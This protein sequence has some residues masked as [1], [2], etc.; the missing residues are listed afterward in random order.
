MRLT[1][2]FVAR[3]VFTC[4]LVVTVQRLEGQVPDNIVP[5]MS[6]AKISRSIFQAERDNAAR[7]R[8]YSPIVEMY[9]Q[10]LWPDSPAQMPLDDMYSLQKV[11][12]SNFLAQDKGRWAELV[13]GSKGWSLLQDNGQRVKLDPLGFASLAFLDL[14]NFDSDT[15]RL[16]YIAPAKLGTVD[17][18]MLSVLPM[19]VKGT[20]RFRGTIWVE[21][22]GFRIIR[23]NGTFQA[24][25]N[26]FAQ[27]ISHFHS[28]CW[29]VEIA[30]GL[31]VPTYVFV[32]D[33]VP[34]KAKGSNGLAHLHIKA[35]IS[36]W[37]YGQGDS[38][39]YAR[40]GMLKDE[41]D[42]PGELV[43][44]EADRLI[45]PIGNV[46][47]SLN[48]IL[49]EVSRGTGFESSTSSCRLLLTAPLELF[50][51]RDTIVLSRG[52]LEM[53]P[54]A[55]TLK[56]LLLYELAHVNVDASVKMPFEYTQSLF[57]TFPSA[58][59]AGLGIPQN[60]ESETKAAALLRGILE[61]NQYAPYLEKASMFLAQLRLIAP[62]IP[63]LTK[64]RFGPDLLEAD[65]PVLDLHSTASFA[66]QSEKKATLTLRTR[67]FVDASTGE[68]ETINSQQ[69]AKGSLF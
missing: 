18:L 32:D 16:A 56:G 14:K 35:R 11:R 31:W 46:E 52:L 10:S 43:G 28:D 19:K 25:R 12:L 66:Q 53:I 13:G 34:W 17:C 68:L 67:Y 37:G 59:F 51:V 27:R 45:A 7:L 47:Q 36:L 54:D 8:P 30:D 60:R 40:S 5:G 42:S 50:H 61:D 3:M 9:I 48:A 24:P 58:R 29:R 15:Y 38:F 21:S 22:R 4:L 20:M 44:L 69:S 41:S 33:S 57:T 64:S 6:G 62:Q 2:R 49:G 26:S 23:I 63:N 55:A 65:L 39:Q 1:I